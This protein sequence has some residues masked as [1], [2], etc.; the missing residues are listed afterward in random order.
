VAYPKK[1]LSDDE[2]IVLETHPHWKTL[3]LPVLELLVI[4]GVAGFLLAIVDPNI[5]KYVILGVAALL[6]VLAFVIPLLRWRTTLF[7][8]TDRRV[9]VRTGILSRTGRDIP[10][11]RVNDVT[12]SHNLIER[13]LGCGT[14][15]VESAGERGQVQLTEV[16][17]VE[18]VQRQLYELVERASHIVNPPDEPGLAR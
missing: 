10:L 7:V 8:L 6:I 18:Q 15:V 5:G 9:V 11:T 17:K 4:C 14:L 3:V 2:A 12:F 16:P 13:M 1:L